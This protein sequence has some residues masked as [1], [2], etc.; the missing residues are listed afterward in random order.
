V[1]AW[2]ELT[3]QHGLVLDPFKD[4][5]QT[6]GTAD[7][8]VIGGWPLSLSMRK[9]RKLGWLGTADSYEAAFNTIGDLARLKLTV[10][11]V[12]EAFSG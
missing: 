4:R 5:A 12:V 10:M 6:F 2:S 7:S 1:Q 8:A 11:P 3:K 9:A